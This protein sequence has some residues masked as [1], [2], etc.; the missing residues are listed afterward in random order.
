MD[1]FEKKIRE[2]NELQKSIVESLT[3]QNEAQEI[4]DALV[5]A[6]VAEEDM[7]E[8]AKYIRREGTPGNY[9]YIYKES[10][11]RNKIEDIPKV[12]Y[13]HDLKEGQQVRTAGGPLGRVV[14]IR[15]NSVRTS[16]SG[17][18]FIHITK[19]F[20]PSGE[21][22]IKEQPEKKEVSS[23]EL[24]RTF[25][26][27]KKMPSDKILKEAFTQQ[28]D[29]KHTNKG[30]KT[31]E[32][33]KQAVQNSVDAYIQ[34]EK[35]QPE[36]KEVNIDS[37]KEGQ[38]YTDKK[39]NKFRIES[40]SGDRVKVVSGGL[41]ARGS[42]E[43]PKSNLITRMKKDGWKLKKSEQ[44]DITKAEQ[45]EQ[46]KKKIKK[47]MDEW[48]NKTLKDKDGNL[49]TDRKRAIAVALSEAGLSNK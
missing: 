21:A 20:R 6:G 40:L 36:K 29:K 12:E 4:V 45:T 5:K 15:G 39:G 30:Y 17:Q 18:D 35:Q 14:E 27:Y 42:S 47:V 9:R 16:E 22:V 44:D 13:K 23:D 37:L 41:G 25:G 49:I 28:L 43:E 3:A 24:V 31:F 34:Q 38:I 7:I 1:S 11:D 19:L 8:K 46:Q 48:K 10:K 26:S 32:S 33:F 2:H